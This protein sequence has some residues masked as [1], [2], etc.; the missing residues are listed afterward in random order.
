[1]E[2]WKEVDW[3]E[4]YRGVLEV[5]DKGNVRRRAYSYE[6]MGRWGRTHVS[7]KSA[8]MLYLDPSSHGYHTVAVQID[9]RRKKFLVHRLVGRAFV[10]GFI[11]GLTINHINGVKTDNRPANLEWVTLAVNTSKQWETGLATCHGDGSPHAKLHSGQVRILRRL[12]KRGVSPGD[13]ATLC[14]VSPSLIYKIR[15][16]ERWNRL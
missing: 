13:L 8:K 2:T 7:S 4:G 9:G 1:M 12:I 11:E 10:P 5:S 15:D 6:C 3:I 14:S 16:G